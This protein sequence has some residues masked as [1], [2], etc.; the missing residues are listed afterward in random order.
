M[1]KTKIALPKKVAGIRIPKTVR[2][3][4]KDV[5]SH[6]MGRVIIAEALVHA[7]SG[8]IRN[9]AQPGS[10]TRQIIGHPLELAQS[11]GS[12]GAGAATAVGTAAGGAVSLIARAIEGLLAYLQSEAPATAREPRVRRQITTKAGKRAR[13]KSGNGKYAEQRT[14]H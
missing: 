12:V 1:A 6:P 10:T 9:Q 4:G 8:L 2:R 7:A 11:V 14:T 3:I 13:R 5:L